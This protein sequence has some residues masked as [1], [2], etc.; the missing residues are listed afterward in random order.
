[1]GVDHL[2]RLAQNELVRRIANHGLVLLGH[3]LYGLAELHKLRLYQLRSSAHRA[4][5]GF[6]EPLQA[7]CIGG[8]VHQK[9]SPKFLEPSFFVS[10]NCD[11]SVIMAEVSIGVSSVIPMALLMRQLFCTAAQLLQEI[12]QRLSL[13]VQGLVKARSDAV[14]G[15]GAASRPTTWVPW[16]PE[17]RAA[18]IMQSSLNSLTSATDFQLD[19]THLADRP[20][21]RVS[22]F[23]L[24][25]VSPG[26]ATPNKM[27]TL[28]T[29]AFR[30]ADCGHLNTGNDQSDEPC[31]IACSDCG[32]S[33]L[34]SRE[35]AA[36]TKHK[37]VGDA[38]AHIEFEASHNSRVV[39]KLSFQILSPVKG[40]RSEHGLLQSES[41]LVQLTTCMKCNSPQPPPSPFS[42]NCST[43]G[44]LLPL[45][46]TV[47]SIDPKALL[48]PPLIQ[49]LQIVHP[50]YLQLLFSKLNLTEDQLL[51]QQSLNLSRHFTTFPMV[52]C[53]EV[54]AMT[55][56]G[57]M[58]G[59]GV[60]ACEYSG[61]PPPDTNSHHPSRPK[62]RKAHCPV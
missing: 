36:N 59:T 16:T 8:R 35:W 50:R 62:T 48:D 4:T 27:C 44:G 30:C 42:M 61:R 1:M 2:L 5:D 40:S 17:L 24:C 41:R 56:V 13:L 45:E 12:D 57:V 51:A 20:T 10:H 7:G 21:S 34:A 33:N 55:Q 19:A 31:E 39:R 18:V 60:T 54:T 6:S 25:T 15:D 38:I 32:N 43:C 58:I 52:E 53:F 22:P 47:Y 37:L 29:L 28:M 46:S 26:T 49:Q 23:R 14:D 3:L 11:L 9:I